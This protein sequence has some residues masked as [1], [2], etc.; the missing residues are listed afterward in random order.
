MHKHTQ[1]A[2]LAARRLPRDDSYGNSE[3]EIT[4]HQTHAR[5]AQ[6]SGICVF[7]HTYSVYDV[8]F[9][10]PMC[11][12]SIALV[13]FVCVFS[14]QVL[15]KTSFA[16]K[17]CM[18]IYCETHA[19]VR[20]CHRAQRFLF[21]PSPQVGWMFPQMYAHARRLCAILWARSLNGDKP[22]QLTLWWGGV[23]GVINVFAHA[24]SSHVL[25][26]ECQGHWH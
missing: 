17:S 16:T 18:N 26:L 23:I 19:Y 13:W 6:V 4:Q 10:I 8:L 12:F 11:V 21:G 5:V 7:Y 2:T 22:I 15:P 24:L 9:V 14:F 1:F 3:A 25:D 20:V